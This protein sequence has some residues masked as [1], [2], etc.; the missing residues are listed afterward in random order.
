MKSNNK[1]EMLR[2]SIY[3]VVNQTTVRGVA[4]HFGVPKTRVHNQLVR[5]TE[6]QFYHEINQRLSQAVRELLDKN[7]RERH[8]R[9][10]EATKRKHMINSK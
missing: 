6:T 8:I 3:F 10:G 1:Q 7:K 5:M 2:Y 9:G 4:K